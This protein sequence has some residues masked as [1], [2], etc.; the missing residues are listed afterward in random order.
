MTQFLPKQIKGFYGSSVLLHRI[1][2]GVPSGDS[3]ICKIFVFGVLY[4]NLFLLFA[5][6]YSEDCATALLPLWSPLPAGGVS[7][8]FAFSSRAA[9][10]P[11]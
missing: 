10:A 8:S 9:R 11:A 3:A 7:N 5:V 2:R 6:Y 1:T 4:V